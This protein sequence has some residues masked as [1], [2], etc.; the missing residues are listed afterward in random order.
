MWWQEKDHLNVINNQLYIGG[1]SVPDLANQFGTPLLVYNIRKVIQNYRK[2]RDAFTNNAIRGIEPRVYYAMKANG[3]PNILKALRNESAFIDAT[4]INEVKAALDVGYE[5]E[6]IIFT[7]LNFGLQHF[8]FLAR[9]GV[10]VNID[11]FSQMQRL[12]EYGPL[13]VSIRWNPGFGVG[14]HRGLEMAGTKVGTLKLGIFKDRIIEAFLKARQ[15]GL[16]PIGLHQ[17]I[18]S[19]WFA[20]Q[21]ADFLKSVDLTL[22]LAE[23]LNSNCNIQLELIDFGGGLGVRS[24]GSYPDFPLEEYSRQIWQ[25]VGRC[26]API[27]RVAIEPGRFIVGNAGILVTTVNMT[28]KKGGFEFVGIDAGFNLFNHY[29]FFGIAPEFIN[30]STVSSSSCHNY[31]IG[32]YL[33]EPS[34]IFAENHRMTTVNEGDILS[35]YPAGAYC[36]SEMARYHLR[37][38]PKELLIDES[39]FKSGETNEQIKCVR[40]VS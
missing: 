16:N 2:V 26:R 33:C 24:K 15:L 30:S 1:T 19:N 37:D 21:L 14:F 13:D 8:E 35:L 6:K 5:P 7:G 34:D 32:G 23:H 40:L 11:S 18:G 22:Q 29:F 17:H 20:D 4:S 3:S 27:R 39:I 25:R 31:T 9:S 36:A 10:L 28:E 38:L 12:A